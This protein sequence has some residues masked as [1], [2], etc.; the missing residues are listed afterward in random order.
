MN[1]AV[2]KYDATYGDPGIPEAQ[3]EERQQRLEHKAER[4]SN[5]RTGR[6]RGVLIPELPWKREEA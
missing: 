3:R 1:D 4:R 2:R 6:T 5:R